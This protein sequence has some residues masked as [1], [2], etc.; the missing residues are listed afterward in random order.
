[1]ADD[2]EPLLD[3][4][5]STAPP[6]VRSYERLFAYFLEG[7]VAHR[8][9]LGASARY[10]GMFSYNGPR[11]DRLEGFSR[12][13]PMLAAWLHG[14]RSPR[15]EV[16]G[17]ASRDLVEILSSGMLA[18]TD[19]TSREYWG[20]TKHWGQSIVEAADLALVLW[21][22]KGEL[23]E[24]LAAA[25]RAAICRWLL[26][27]NGKRIPNN[28][29]H[30]FVVQVNAVLK[31]L[32][33]KH[34]A[35]ELASHYAHAKAFY[36]G[37]GWFRDGDMPA[38]PAFDY[39]NAWGFHYHLQWLRR[40]MPGLDSGFIDESL[41]QFCAVY[42]YFFGPEGFP[43]MGRS[44]CYRMAA[45]VPLVFAQESHPCVVSAGEARRALDVTWQY[46]VRRGAVARGNV[47]QGYFDGDPRLLEDY[48]GPASCLWALRSLV[49]AFALRPE[50][51][52]WTT[53]P[54]PLPVEKGDFEL[55]LPQP[56]WILRGSRS[57]NSIVIKT[58]H[59]DNPPL[60]SHKLLDRILEQFTRKPRRPK[61]HEAKYCR[62]H[63]DSAVPFCGLPKQ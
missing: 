14:G 42:R 50:S 38:R 45:P 55:R 28:N 48:S 6:G 60:E 22:T 9:P 1:M 35:Q 30:L 15:P 21:L 47:T 12:V 34:D 61:N 46:F 49:A 26:Q 20:D 8:S 57:T 29:W 44:A 54:E 37:S 4:F 36:A 31:A 19:P 32:G 3:D 24:R 10:P 27:V 51:A 53:A 43:I 25:E 18:G 40:I 52:F 16:P 5:K 41:A 23:W 11:M 33:E 2:L 58:A 62:S 39:Y 7:F 56:G 59:E 63:Y 13:A 17:G